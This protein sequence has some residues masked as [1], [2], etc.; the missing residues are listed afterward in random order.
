MDDILLAV[1][2]SL[3][4]PP[5]KVDLDLN[6]LICLSIP[7]TLI[8]GGGDLELYIVIV[9]D[10]SPFLSYLSK[11]SSSDT[12]SLRIEVIIELFDESRLSIIVLKAFYSASV[13][14]IIGFYLI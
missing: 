7:A 14:D 12:I 5:F 8:L 6:L 10:L 9:F 3:T 2:L 1:G 4:A 11:S 13:W